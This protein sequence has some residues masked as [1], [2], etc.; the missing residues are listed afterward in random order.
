MIPEWGSGGRK[1]K[2]SHPD[3]KKPLKS[4]VS[5]AFLYFFPKSDTR[6]KAGLEALEKG[7]GVKMG[8]RIQDREG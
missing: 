4:K 3:Q 2:S 1:F 8:V 6:F 5:R 7:K